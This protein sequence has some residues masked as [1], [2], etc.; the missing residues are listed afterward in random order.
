MRAIVT[1]IKVGTEIVVLY[2]IQLTVTWQYGIMSMM[3]I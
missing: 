1:S 3:I 2:H